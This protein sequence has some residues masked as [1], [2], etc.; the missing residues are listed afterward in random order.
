MRSSFYRTV[1]RFSRPSTAN[2]VSERPLSAA[3]VYSDDT[4]GSALPAPLR[5]KKSN[6]ATNPNAQT[7]NTQ[8]S[9]QLNSQP[10]TD[11]RPKSSNQIEPVSVSYA[12]SGRTKYA[13]KI[14]QPLEDTVVRNIHET[15]DRH[16]DEFVTIETGRF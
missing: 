15:G 7:S 13:S 11:T 10:K 1:G 16:T 14:N 2:L 8:P 6:V 3:S 4:D 12:K 5:N 9:S